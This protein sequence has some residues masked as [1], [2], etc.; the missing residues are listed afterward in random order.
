M[1]FNL[2]ILAGRLAAP[3]DIR[4]PDGG[5]T[6]ARL[7]LAVRSAHPVRVDVVPV[8][9]A[10]LGVRHDLA[11]EIATGALAPGATLWVA[12]S[13]ERRFT[14]DEDGRRSRVEVL[15]RHIEIR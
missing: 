10:D 2:V 15:A 4:T 14:D 3:I 11:P 12:G 9:L 6:S 1:D 8:V 7:L 5:P 13:I